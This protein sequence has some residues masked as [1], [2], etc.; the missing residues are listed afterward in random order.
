MATSTIKPVHAGIQVPFTIATSSWATTSPYTYTWTDSRVTAGCRVEV[1]FDSSSTD[2]S[3]EYISFEKVSGGIKFTAPSIPTASIA[4]V[5]TLVNAQTGNV[6][7]IQA[8]D[9]SISNTGISGAANVNEALTSL[10]EQIKKA[11]YT[12][13]TTSASGN[14]ATNIDANSYYCVG[15]YIQN[16]AC[17]TFPYKSSSGK[18]AIHVTNTNMEV[19]NNYTITF[20]LYYAERI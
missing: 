13:V 19:L 3:V 6:Q 14:Y 18:I 9:V 16:A 4:V 11:T 15:V 12:S 8:S 10:N 17:L 7:A 1:A 2:A 5:V 20:E